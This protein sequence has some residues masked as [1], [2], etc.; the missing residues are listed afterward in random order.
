MEN[1]LFLLEIEIR[2]KMNSYNSGDKEVIV[3]KFNINLMF[4]IN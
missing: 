2:L 3:K 1:Y 4:Q